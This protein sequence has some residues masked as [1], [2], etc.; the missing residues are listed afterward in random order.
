MFDWDDANVRHIARHGVSPEEAE[1][2]LLNQPLDLDEQLRNH[3]RRI[4]H[5]GETNSGRI[6]NVVATKRDKRVRV[7][8]AYPADRS[9][10]RLYA[11]EKRKR[12]TAPVRDA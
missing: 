12:D 2:V 10:R 11:S 4:L 6:L 7:V 1:Q 9:D 8:T 3:E 5:L